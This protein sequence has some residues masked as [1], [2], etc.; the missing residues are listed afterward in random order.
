MSGDDGESYG[1]S[2]MDDYDEHV[3]D[4][5]DYLSNDAE[6]DDGDEYVASNDAEDNDANNPNSV[7]NS[8]AFRPS[9]DY[10]KSKGMNDAHVAKETVEQLHLPL[11]VLQKT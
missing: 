10:R 3:S 7:K 5:D 2:Q 4:D 9:F 6:D 1:T 8:K 11:L